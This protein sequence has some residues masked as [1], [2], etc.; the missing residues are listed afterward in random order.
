MQSTSLPTRMP[1][2]FAD[3][4]SKQTIPVGSQIGIADG[5]A[6]FTDGFPPL[7]RTPIAAGGKPPFGTDMNGVLNAI[8]QA[9][10]W[11][12]SGA[13]WTFN[14]DFATSI[15]GYPR[16]AMIPSTDGAGF[17]INSAES[18]TTDPESSASANW[19]PVLHR[20]SASVELGGSAVTL[21]TS[22]AAK[23][24]I[25]L[26]GTLTANVTVTFPAWRKRW[27]V[28]NQC[29]GSYIVT[30]AVGSGASVQVLPGA[31][32][33][34]FGDGTNVYTQQ[35]LYNGLYTLTASATLTSAHAGALVMLGSS[36]T[37]TLPAASAFRN[38]DAVTIRSATPVGNTSSVATVGN[39]RFVTPG[40]TASAYTLRGGDSLTLVSDGV[41]RWAM[42]VE[43][44]EAMVARLFSYQQSFGTNGYQKHPGG[45]VEVWGEGQTNSSGLASV[46]FPTTFP[47]ACRQVLATPTTASASAQN[48]IVTTGPL[49]TTGLTIY[50]T[51]ATPGNVPSAASVGFRYHALG[52]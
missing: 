18:N 52:Y 31:T 34:V 29:T 48:Y 8:T 39:D 9:I 49:S 37:I 1:V 33:N 30:L 7:T 28:I 51:G 43:S 35:P 14:A 13:G 10:R 15:G 46:T 19:L 6:S 25:I 12:N 20:G 36:A 47:N 38:G 11:I 32:A 44:T 27:Q 50:T 45:F 26:T 3:Q 2:P 4:G 42:A 40:G 21:T 22:Q 24:T 5:R 17:W 23:D 41:S 16:G